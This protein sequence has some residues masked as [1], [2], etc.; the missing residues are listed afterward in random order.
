MARSATRERAPRSPLGL[1][2]TAA[3]ISYPGI[4]R[5]MRPPRPTEAWQTEVWR[6]WDEVGEFQ[7]ATNWGANVCSRATFKVMLRDP[8]TNVL[9]EADGTHPAWALL[10][11]L[12]GGRDKQGEFIR[13]ASL[14]LIVAG[15]G[16]LVNRAVVPEDGQNV[17]DT[18]YLWE[19]VGTEE[20]R[21]AGDKWWLHYEGAEQIELD[22]NDVVIRVWRPHPK[23]RR[24]AV[25][26]SKSALPI[27]REIRRY[28]LHIESQTDSR[29]TGNGLV[30]FPDTITI[31]PPEGVNATLTSADLITASLLKV[32]ELSKTGIG[33]AQAQTPIVM[34]APADSIGKIKHITF[35][36]PL[37]EKAHEMRSGAISRLATT[38]DTPKEVVTG[39]G[40]MN[41]W[42][43]WQVD[44]SSV[45]SHIEP[46]LTALTTIVTTD[47][48]QPALDDI[49]VV[50]IADTSTLRLRPNRSK[51][52]VELFDRG[53]LSGKALRRE[54]GFS[55]DDA[56][57]PEDVERWIRMQMVKASWDP[58][59]ARAAAESLGVVLDIP[60]PVDQE[61]RE[62]RPTPSL[63]EHPVHAE[64]EKT[65]SNGD[66]RSNEIAASAAWLAFR[67]MERAGNRLI[68]VTGK[69]PDIERE[70]THTA[71]PVHKDRVEDLLKESFDC[72]HRNDVPLHA[73]ERARD[74]CLNL[75]TSGQPFSIT[76]AMRFIE[77]E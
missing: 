2:L 34:T 25:A 49:N 65:V 20:I 67:A 70:N 19:V 1:S 3:S 40:E 46:T 52:A 22:E 38:L 75:L 53:E 62:A 51:E 66:R 68:T 5:D 28:D 23:N 59:T 10:D 13:Q 31:K 24:L 60:M 69:K 42:G 58:L 54:T 27:L 61:P 6:L 32:A 16:S 11:E 4:V 73:S 71:I 43:A 8:K 33:T 37:D 56:P 9:S 45:K 63:K 7:F 36:S 29:L 76:A 44:E 72:A 26:A 18:G 15:E 35:W 55:E 64:P 17:P 47:Y 50:I 48:I 14:H 12:T 77:G 21:F 41:R 30:I 74:Y 57:K 39:T